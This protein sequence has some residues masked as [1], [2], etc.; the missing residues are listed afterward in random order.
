MHS[1]QTVVALFALLLI[2][3]TADAQAPPRYRLFDVVIWYAT[4]VDSAQYEPAVR[5]ELAQFTQRVKSYRPRPRPAGLGGEMKMVYAAREGYETKLV[6]SAATS[7]VETLAQRYVDELRPCYEW[8]SFHDCP[9]REAEF[10]E[11]HLAANPNTPFRE[12]LLL[13]VAHRWI[14]A[15]EGYESEGMPEQAGRARRASAAPLAAALKSRSLLLR[16]AADELRTSR[17]CYS[18]R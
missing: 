6:A 14:C 16:T 3:T 12:F 18:E 17:R 7:G 9:E 11:Q 2:A 10:A 4:R 5:Q 1:R 8:E 15:A 13:L